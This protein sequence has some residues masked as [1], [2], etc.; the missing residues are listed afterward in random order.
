MISVAISGVVRWAES[1]C[2]RVPDEIIIFVSAGRLSMTTFDDL[3]RKDSSLKRCG[4]KQESL[5]SL[6]DS[7]K[8]FETR[9]IRPIRIGPS[10]LAFSDSS[11]GNR[12]HPRNAAVVGNLTSHHRWTPKDE[13]LFVGKRKT[14]A[15]PTI[16]LPSERDLG[17]YA[18]YF[19]NELMRNAVRAYMT[20]V[21]NRGGNA[22]P[23]LELCASARPPCQRR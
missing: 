2:Y 12:D 18:S 6:K 4:I 3:P 20:E 5:Q 7:M 10:G 9:E 19:P 11:H 16:V 1:P 17:P 14:N 15:V 23:R 21:Y 22:T 13:I 8:G